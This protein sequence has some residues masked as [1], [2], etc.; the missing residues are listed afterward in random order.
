MRATEDEHV[1]IYE[2]YLEVS[3]NETEYVKAVTPLLHPFNVTVEKFPYRMTNELPYPLVP[4]FNESLHVDTEMSF[5]LWPFDS[6]EDEVTTEFIILTSHHR[7]EC[8]SCFKYNRDTLQFDFRADRVL[9]NTT[10]KFEVKYNDHHGLISYFFEI[11]VEPIY[12]VAAV[13]KPELEDDYILV[14]ELPEDTSELLTPNEEILK[15]FSESPWG[16]LLSGKVLPHSYN[17]R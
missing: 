8:P 2:L 17:E 3:L 11:F 9:S 12:D 13:T 15:D 1:G 16:Y 10:S 7:A 5:M 6:D 14:D 4:L